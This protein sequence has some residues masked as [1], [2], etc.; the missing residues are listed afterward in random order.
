MK[1][2]GVAAALSALVFP[3]I[4]QYYMGRKVRALL[5]LVIAA[6]CGIV[7]FNYQ[8]DTAMT[9][10]DQIM[11]GSVAL[12]PAAIEARI[13]AHPTPLRVT[14]AGIAFL[15]CWAGSLLEIY[16]VP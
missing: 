11:S 4:G 5:F 13:A 3:G 14:L 8:L 7:Y 12:D 1:R 10:S 9:V 16:L 15:L 2:K 6:V